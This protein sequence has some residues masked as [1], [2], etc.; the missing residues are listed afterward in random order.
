V[1]DDLTAL[2]V[3]ELRAE[4]ADL[5]QALA[6]ALDGPYPIAGLPAALSACRVQGEIV[7][8]CLDR[9]AEVY[10]TREADRG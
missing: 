7:R 1:A 4:L 5:D 8:R 6:S 3:D 10:P 9:F 2:T